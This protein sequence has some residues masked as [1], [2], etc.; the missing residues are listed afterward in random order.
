MIRTLISTLRGHVGRGAAIVIFI[1]RQTLNQ[2]ALA[3]QVRRLS[4]LFW[5]NNQRRGAPRAI[6][7]MPPV[8]LTLFPVA[9]SG[10]GFYLIAVAVELRKCMEPRN[11]STS[12][13]VIASGAAG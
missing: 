12:L 10:H 11:C 13:L 2:S 9:S 4:F 3:Q 8:Q 1:L 6:F 5:Q 7:S